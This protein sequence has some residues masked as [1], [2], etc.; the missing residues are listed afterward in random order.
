MMR[1][2]LH[3]QILTVDA[4]GSGIRKLALTDGVDVPVPAGGQV[5]D[6][7]ASDP[8]ARFTLSRPSMYPGAPGAGAAQC[9]AQRPAVAC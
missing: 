5:V 1:P 3:T 6:F 7:P 8:G 4:A 2:L 9:C